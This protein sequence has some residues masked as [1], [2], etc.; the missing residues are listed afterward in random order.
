MAKKLEI[1]EW[2]EIQRVLKETYEIWSPG[3]TRECYRDFVLKQMQHPWCR[4]N[5]Q[6]LIV[7]DKKKSKTPAAS[8]KYYKLNF[9]YRGKTLKFAGFGAIY[10]RKDLR[11]HGY[12]TDLI[13]LA[14][15]KAWY[16]GCHG[17]ILFSDIAP[18]FYASFGFFDLN[19]EKFVLSLKQKKS[20]S[21]GQ[22]A[23]S[24]FEPGGGT[25]AGTATD[26]QTGAETDAQAG[27]TTNEQSSSGNQQTNT[28]ADEKTSTALDEQQKSI[29]TPTNLDMQIPGQP[30][31][32]TLTLP[33]DTNVSVGAMLA[34]AE[35]GHTGPADW[36][37]GFVVEGD[38]VVQCRHLTTDDDQIDFITRHYGRWLRKQPYGVERSR[39]YFHF[40]I[41][42]ENYLAKNSGLSWPRLELLSIEDK[43]VSGYAIIEY[44]GRVV[45]I[46]ELIGDENTRRLLWKGVIA[47]TQDLDAIRISGWEAVL[48]DLQPGFSLNQ[49]ATIDD[50]IKESCD[51]LGFAEK[52]KGRAMILPFKEELEDWL[53]ICPSP[54]L[55]LDHL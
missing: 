6:Y 10:T 55:E 54:I 53:T 9:N 51:S 39:L 17:T 34:T 16:D 3:L 46:L 37:T 49:L 47:R 36:A 44:G 8:L 26:A 7:R 11:G 22:S 25:A 24:Q 4:W 40:K 15:D 38:I 14:L 30:V 21:N 52:Q 29:S 50:T 19:N 18:E 2:C 41:T 42:R 31:V 1:A 45:R 12:A 48:T 35:H 13:K 23:A 27:I 32:N 28:T 20:D 33:G 5:Y 43:H